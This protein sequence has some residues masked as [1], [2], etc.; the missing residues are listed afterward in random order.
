MQGAG[1]ARVSWQLWT[2]LL[3][4]CCLTGALWAALFTGQKT[5]VVDGRLSYVTLLGCKWFQ[6]KTEMEVFHLDIGFL[7]ASFLPIKDTFDNRALKYKC[8]SYIMWVFFFFYITDSKSSTVGPAVSV[9]F[10]CI[11]SLWYRQI[12]C[13]SK[14]FCLLVYHVR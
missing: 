9:W 7:L 12:T 14:L 10:C 2:T 13:L 1:N 8:Q 4:F 11:T 6:Q 3:E 5:T